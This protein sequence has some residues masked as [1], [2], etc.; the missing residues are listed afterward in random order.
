MI[1]NRWIIIN[2]CGEWKETVAV[3]QSNLQLQSNL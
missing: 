1:Q 2:A 3:W